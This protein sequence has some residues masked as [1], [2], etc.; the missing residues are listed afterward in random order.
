LDFDAYL[1]AIRFIDSLDRSYPENFYVGWVY[2]VRNTEFR[3]PLIKI[4][5]TTRPPHDRA[6]ELG[7][8]GVPG[9]FELVYFVHVGDARAAEGLAHQAL[10]RHRY[11]SNREFFEVSIGQAVSVL[12]QVADHVPLLRSQANEGSRNPRSKPIPQAFGLA[13]RACPSC[14]KKNRVRVLAI[15]TKP[16]CGSCAREMPAT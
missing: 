7:G 12:D 13:I 16:K 8:T 5:M 3:R 2:A 11:Q 1:A 10:A 9:L 4:G 15:L 6:A 14:G